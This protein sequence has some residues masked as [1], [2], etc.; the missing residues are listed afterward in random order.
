MHSHFRETHTKILHFWKSPPNPKVPSTLEDKN[1]SMRLKQKCTTSIHFDSMLFE[2]NTRLEI[3][4]NLKRTHFY[5][6]FTIEIGCLNAKTC[7]LVKYLL[8]YS[9]KH[10]MQFYWKILKEW[11]NDDFLWRNFEF[12]KNTFTRSPTFHD[13]QKDIYYTK[14]NIS[15]VYDANKRE[16]EN[17]LH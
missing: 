6:F 17:I 15:C 14:N 3:M 13:E 9:K 12:L 11:S 5:H 1:F 10:D 2:W 8:Y 7:V 16:S 4:I